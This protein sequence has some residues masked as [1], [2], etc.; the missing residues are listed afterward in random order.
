MNNGRRPN[1]H[2]NGCNGHEVSEA[3]AFPALTSRENQVL[4]WIAAGKRDRE[5]GAILCVSSRT[6]QKHVEHILEK[7][8]V[9]TR[10]AAAAWWHGHG[11]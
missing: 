11:R 7:L 2:D 4:E 6:V 10:G 8:R 9:E 3:I 5:I 1:P